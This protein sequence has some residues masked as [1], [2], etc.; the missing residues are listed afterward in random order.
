MTP[1]QHVE[2]VSVG[3]KSKYR[4]VDGYMVRIRRPRR[5]KPTRKFLDDHGYDYA[6]NKRVVSCG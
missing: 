6:G 3:E 5:L 4:I 1:V 2:I